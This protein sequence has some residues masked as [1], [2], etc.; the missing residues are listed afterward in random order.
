M[1]IP[2]T[3]FVATPHPS[4]AN[5]PK[6]GDAKPGIFRYRPKTARPPVLAS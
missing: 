3:T 4:R 2:V 1:F 5:P 6:G